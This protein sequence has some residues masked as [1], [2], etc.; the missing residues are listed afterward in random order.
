MYGVY[1]AETL[2][3]LINTIHQ[4]YNI[5]TPNK[6]L[7]NGKLGTLFIWYINKNGI[8]HYAINTP[9]YLRTLREKYIKIYEEFI[10]H[11]KQ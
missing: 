10:M 1:N 9:L 2:E 11:Q 3:K 6:R 4:M 5:T 8:H 7:F